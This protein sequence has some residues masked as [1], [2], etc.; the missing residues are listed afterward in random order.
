MSSGLKTNKQTKKNCDAKGKNKPFLWIFINKG[1]VSRIRKGMPIG[2]AE[3]IQDIKGWE[4][5]EALDL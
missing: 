1:V 2:E 5:Q 4:G 3:W